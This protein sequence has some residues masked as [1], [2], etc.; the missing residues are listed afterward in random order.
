MYPYTEKICDFVQETRPGKQFSPLFGRINQ[1][2]TSGE[3]TEM[4]FWGRL[5]TARGMLLM[6]EEYESARELSSACD[7]AMLHAGIEEDWI[8]TGYDNIDELLQGELGP[9]MF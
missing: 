4:N 5:D 7:E 9:L 8:R 2:V 6:D 3:S 1:F